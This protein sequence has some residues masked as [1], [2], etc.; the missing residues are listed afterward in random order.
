[1]VAAA[2]V[3]VATRID[4][5]DGDNPNISDIFIIPP[6]FLM[7][8]C[9]FRMAIA[10]IREFFNQ[11]DFD[12]LKNVNINDRKVQVSLVAAGIT[13]IYIVHQLSK[14]RYKLPPGPRPWPIVGNFFC[15]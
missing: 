4:N 7:S 10:G 11:L 1:M 15:K 9:L 6:S 8:I 3:A 5:Y 13:S 12:V 2:A 14:R